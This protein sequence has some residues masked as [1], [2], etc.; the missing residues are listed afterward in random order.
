MTKTEL[1]KQ[2]ALVSDAAE[3]LE[4]FGQHELERAASVML[5]I[6]K[7]A[8]IRDNT[9]PVGIPAKCHVD[10]GCGTAIIVWEPG[11]V[12]GQIATCPT[13]KMQYDDGGWLKGV[14]A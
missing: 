5:R 7:R 14:A 11:Q 2:S 12:A 6:T 9:V 10:C 8:L 13:C 3:T 1:N 4:R